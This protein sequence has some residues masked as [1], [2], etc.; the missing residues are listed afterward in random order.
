MS[1]YVR[2]R[3]GDGARCG[4]RQHTRFYTVHAIDRTPLIRN[5]T[6]RNQ[7]TKVQ[8]KIKIKININIKINIKIKC[9]R[10]TGRSVQSSPPPPQSG[11][12]PHVHTFAE[13]Y[14]VGA[15]VPQHPAEVVESLRYPSVPL[16]SRVGQVDL[17]GPTTCTHIRA[18]WREATA[19]NQHDET[20]SIDPPP[21]VGGKGQLGCRGNGSQRHACSGGRGGSAARSSRTNSTECRSPAKQDYAVRADGACP[22]NLSAFIMPTISI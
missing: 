12:S 3:S 11:P 16:G 4:K 7:K 15:G 13:E 10:D 17:A 5:T 19:G 18:G 21:A 14:G 20:K 1:T 22:R 9:H 6:Q 2:R 8:I